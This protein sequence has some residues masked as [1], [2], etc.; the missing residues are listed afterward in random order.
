[1]SKLIT[2]ESCYFSTVFLLEL[3][4]LPSLAFIPSISTVCISYIFPLCGMLS[5]YA[6]VPHRW[7]ITTSPADRGSGQTPMAPQVVVGMGSGVNTPIHPQPI[8]LPCM[9]A[10]SPVLVM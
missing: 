8:L 10:L 4:P 6:Q 9:G 5:F 7:C 1:M 3:D 2:C